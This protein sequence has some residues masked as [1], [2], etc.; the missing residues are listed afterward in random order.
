M[1]LIA[2]SVVIVLIASLTGFSPLG[3]KAVSCWAFENR[4]VDP[5][6]RHMG[7]GRFRKRRLDDPEALDIMIA[8]KTCAGNSR[9]LL[10]SRYDADAPMSRATF[11]RIT[12]RPFI[13]PRADAAHWAL[14]GRASALAADGRLEL[15][16]VRVKLRGW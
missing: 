12:Y 3:G 9:C 2:A 11:N 1:P 15:L 6:C 16:N 14:P 8:L 4:P 10:P 13:W 5:D 7:R